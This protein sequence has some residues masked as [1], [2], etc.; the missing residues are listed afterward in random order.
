MELASELDVSRLGARTPRCL[1]QRLI[2]KVACVRI[3]PQPH[4]PLWAEC[5]GVNVPRLMSWLCLWLILCH[6][7]SF[8]PCFLW[9][10]HHQEVGGACG[11]VSVCSAR[12]R[13]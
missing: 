2:S 13:R 6:V 7:L 4:Q 11:F 1:K 3:H 10:T 5:S 9:R 8:F 12:R